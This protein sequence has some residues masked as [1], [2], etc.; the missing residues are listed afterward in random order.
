MQLT[1]LQAILVVLVFFSLG[2]LIASKTKAMMSMRFIS[3]ALI[4]AAFWMG[5]PAD[6]FQK[7]DGR[8]GRPGQK[9]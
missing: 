9:I 5:M 8:T 1:Q 7:T 6:L 4:L 2:D 3:S